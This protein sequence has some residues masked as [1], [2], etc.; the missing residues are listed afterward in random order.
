MK[1]TR[2]QAFD[3]ATIQSILNAS[4]G[5]T[6]VSTSSNTFAWNGVTLYGSAASNY[7]IVAYSSNEARWISHDASVGGS[8]S[9]GSNVMAVSDLNVG[10]SSSDSAR[11]DHRHQGIATVTASSSNTMQRP[12]L[13]LRAGTNVSFGLT[14]TDGDAALDTITINSTASGGGGSLTVADEGSPLSTAA[15]TLDFVGAGVTATGAG[16][17]K[18]ITIA[19]GG[20]S[21]DAILGQSGIG[22]ARISGLQASPD[23]DVAAT[24]DDEFNTT[25]TSDPMTGW[26][27]LGTPTAHDINSTF[28]SHYY[29][30]KAAASGTNL[31]GIYK[32]IPST[33][34]TVTCKVSAATYLNTNYVRGGALFV[35]ETSPGKVQAVHPVYDSFARIAI[36]AYTNPTTFASNTASTTETHGGSPYYLRIVC[37]DTTHADYQFSH[38]GMVWYSLAGNVATGFTIGSVGLFVDPEQ[39]SYAVEACFDWIRFT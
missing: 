25:D 15:T 35:A 12:V 13:N 19:G 1:V 21:S 20:G 38:D 32:A 5:D 22:G 23:I 3:P 2:F 28:K 11:M 17:T 24:N 14:S 26:T 18:T 37:A 39:T 7:H 34:F 36:V 33:P 30:K 9:F 8:V 31:T 29:V 6:V 27:T 4:N 16:A 10:G